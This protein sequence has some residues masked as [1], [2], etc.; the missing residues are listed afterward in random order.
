MIRGMFFDLG[1]TLCYPAS[2]NW[3][4][5]DR[6]YEL[7]GREAL[8]SLPEERLEAALSAGMKYLDDNH[9]ILTE[10]EEAEQFRQYYAML[11][12]ALPEI[13]LSQGQVGEIARDRVYNM[14]NYMFYGDVVSNIERLSRTYRLGVISDTWPSAARQLRSAGIYDYFQSFTLSCALGV[15]KPDPKMYEHALSGLGL[16]P[17]ETLFVDDWP[18]NLEGA[19]RLGI[20]PVLICRGNRRYSDGALPG[21]CRTVRGLAELP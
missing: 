4:L 15:F 6:F 2:G 10:D 13:G 1:W 3:M 19:E 18:E 16:P 20:T 8:S 5:T 21:G 12:E 11:A 7:A 17:E 14:D 9:L